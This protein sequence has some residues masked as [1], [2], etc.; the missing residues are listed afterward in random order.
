[1]VMAKQVSIDKL[2]NDLIG[3]NVAIHGIYNGSLEE[4]VDIAKSIVENGLNLSD[5]WKTILGSAVS[6]GNSDNVNIAQDLREYQYGYGERCNVVIKVPEIITNSEGEK[7][8]LGFPSY[9]KTTVA[10]QYS[11]TCVLDQICSSLGRVPS[12]FVYGY[13]TDSNTIE[14]NPNYYD[15]L[16]QDRKDN[17]FLQLKSSMNDFSKLISDCVIDENLEKLEHLKK[18]FEV[19][20]INEPIIESA[21]NTLKKQGNSIAKSESMEIKAY[22]DATIVTKISSFISGLPMKN[23]LFVKQIDIDAL[24]AEST[25]LKNLCHDLSSED[26][27]QIEN[28]NVDLI[29]RTFNLVKGLPASLKPDRIIE[30]EIEAKLCERQE[31]RRIILTNEKLDD[32]AK[33]SE[34]FDKCVAAYL[35]D[36]GTDMF[37]RFRTLIRD[38]N[39]NGNHVNL[40][41]SVLKLGDAFATKMEELQN[42][43]ERNSKAWTFMLPHILQ[44]Y[45]VSKNIGNEVYNAERHKDFE[46]RLI[47]LGLV[48]LKK[49]NGVADDKKVKSKNEINHDSPDKSSERQKIMLE[50]EKL[51]LAMCQYVNT[52]M[53][54]IG[55]KLN[56]NGEILR[57]TQMDKMRREARREEYEHRKMSEERNEKNRIR[58]EVRTQPISVKEEQKQQQLRKQENKQVSRLQ[59]RD[60]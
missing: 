34:D 17:L 20:G 7:I 39:R 19:R 42:N 12:E 22:S 51:K 49:E 60:R 41:D 37:G 3:Y 45:T 46:E 40:G 43:A 38:M 36:G 26:I 59:M 32:K 5:N 18:L 13:Y 8:Y 2:I 56:S 30:D 52:G 54:P 58:I 10:Q 28:N 24:L 11:S 15:E 27:Q 55:Y 16:P 48:E 14:V 53:L 23:R 25:I 4:K 9:N 29:T 35:L 21:L 47:N 33:L 50:H 1:M 31:R 44:V 57:E 6:L